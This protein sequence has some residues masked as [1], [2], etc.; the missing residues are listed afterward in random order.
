MS[1]RRVYSEDTLAIMNRFFEAF[2]AARG[3]G[4]IKSITNFC[5]SNGIDK[6]HF[7]AQRKD[8]GRGFFE[9]GWLMPL[10]RNYGVSTA[11]LLSGIEPMFNA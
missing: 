2:D 4:R 8:L 7:Y 9:V 6:R 11:W 3:L 1:R 5:E 10:V